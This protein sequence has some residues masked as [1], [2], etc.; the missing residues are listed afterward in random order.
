MM[1]R[2]LII[3]CLVFNFQLSI[4]EESVTSRVD[5]AWGWVWVWFKLSILVANLGFRLS[6]LTADVVCDEKQGEV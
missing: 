5:L 2:Y 3:G 6:C 4:D 1:K